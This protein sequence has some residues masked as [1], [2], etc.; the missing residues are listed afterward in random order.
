M[1]CKNIA[2]NFQKHRNQCGLRFSRL[3]NENSIK[4]RARHNADLFALLNQVV[5]SS[6]FILVLFKCPISVVETIPIIT[7]KTFYLTII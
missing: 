5:Y 7:R 3:T 2:K 1:R 6:G 4:M